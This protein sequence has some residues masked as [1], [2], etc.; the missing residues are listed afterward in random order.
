MIGR[1]VQEELDL[2]LLELHDVAQDPRRK[3]GDDVPGGHEP[4]K[5]HVVLRV[6]ET[7]VPRDPLP[8]RVEG[9]PPEKHRLARP[10]L[11]VDAHGGIQGDLRLDPWYELPNLNRDDPDGGVSSMEEWAC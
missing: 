3:P 10:P 7:E 4:L 9:E 11:S 8:E 1:L 2:L 6:S 5:K